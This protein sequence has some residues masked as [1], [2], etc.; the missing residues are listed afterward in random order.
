MP[1]SRQSILYR[2][3]GLLSQRTTI[4]KVYTSS[5]TRNDRHDERFCSAFS[6]DWR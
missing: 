4:S 2:I 6:P 3:F 1:L 5:G